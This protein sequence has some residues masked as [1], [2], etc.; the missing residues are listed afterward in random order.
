[1][2]EQILR[3]CEE[4]DDSVDYTSNAL[5]DDKLLNSVTLITII[6]ELSDA[7]DVE[8]PFEEITPENFNSINAMAKLVQKYV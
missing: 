6:S 2:E 1:M 5:M 7:F 3:I 8:I 4:A